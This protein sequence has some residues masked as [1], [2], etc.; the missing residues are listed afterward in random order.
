MSYTEF[1]R[2][3]VQS[4][5]V[6]FR[7]NECESEIIS[8]EIGVPD[9]NFEAEKVRDSYSDNE[10]SAHCEKCNEEYD[11]AVWCS[12]AD[13]YI[14]VFDI[15]DEDIIEIIVKEEEELTEY[16][17]HQ[18]ES[19]LQFSSLDIFKNEIE[20][21]KKLNSLAVEDDELM[22]TL[23]RR[24]YSGAITCLEVYLSDTLI[25]VVLTNDNI[26]KRFVRTFY[27][28]RNRKFQLSEI[29]DKINHIQDIAKKELLDVI[30]HDLAKVK[31]MYEDTLEIEFPDI[32][33]LSKAILIRHDMVHR[34]GKTKDGAEVEINEDIIN[35]IITKVE[36]FV[37][38]LDKKI[39]H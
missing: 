33:N 13:A 30:Y 5:Q 39:E 38:E 16:Y 35:D 20:N 2:I 3:G 28:I 14:E 11:I 22:K 15:D 26:F 1:D 29:Y 21:L 27:G 8:E 17:E 4:I 7:C 19:I 23:K 12:F 18:I 6:K 36:T 9:P 37:N 10:G 32:G 31:G 25:H 34:N 24:I